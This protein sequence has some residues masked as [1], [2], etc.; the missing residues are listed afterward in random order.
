MS[1][2]LSLDS[3]SILPVWLSH[4]FID[5][6]ENFKTASL[7]SEPAG[8]QTKLPSGL[9]NLCNKHPL[10]ADDSNSAI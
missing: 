3:Y 10:H 9:W 7:L 4:S 8:R 2:I 1:I 5:T 6:G